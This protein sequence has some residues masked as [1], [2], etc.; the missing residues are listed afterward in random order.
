MKQSSWLRNGPTNFSLSMK[1]SANWK[2]RTLGGARWSNYG[3]LAGSALKKRPRCL[4]SI[5]QR[6][7]VIG[8]GLRRGSTGQSQTLMPTLEVVARGVGQTKTAMTI[9]AANFHEPL[10][11]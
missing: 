5:P 9:S 10:A 4:R 7:A 11:L 2:K 6:L 3:I 8:A 1:H